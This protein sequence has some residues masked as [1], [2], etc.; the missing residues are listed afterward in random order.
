[1]TPIKQN[2]SLKDFDIYSKNIGLFINNKS[3][4]SSYFGLILTFFYCT[5]FIIILVYYIIKTVNK[6]QLKAYNSIRY[7]IETPSIKLNNDLFY[8]AFGAE[9][10]NNTSVFIDET[11]YYPKVIYYN[12]VKENDIWRNIEKL[13]LETEKCNLSKFNNG[14]KLLFKNNTLSTNYCVKDFGNIKLSGSYS[15]NEMA[16][17]KIILYPCKN[18]TKNS[19][20]CKPQN[21]IDQYLSASYISVQMQD[22]GITPTDYKNPTIPIIQDLYTSIGKSFYKEMLIFY[23]IVEIEND[24]GLFSKNTE[25]KTYIKFDR[26]FDTMHLRDESEYYE[27]KSLCRALIRLSDTIEVYNRIYGKMAEVFATTG[28]YLQF[29]NSLFCMLSFIFNNYNMK[30]T[31]IDNLFNYNLIKNKLVLKHDIE[32]SNKNEEYKSNIL[33]PNSYFKQKNQNSS[34]SYKKINSVQIIKKD[35]TKNN[36]NCIDNLKPITE[37]KFNL[38]SNQKSEKFNINDI[39]FNKMICTDKIIGNS[40][41]YGLNK[42]NN[43]NILNLNKNVNNF[44]QIKNVVTKKKN[45]RD[46]N[47]NIISFKFNIFEYYF[48]RNCFRTNNKSKFCLYEYGLEVIKNQLDIINVFNAN[49]FFNVLFKRLTKVRNDDKND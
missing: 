39:N 27:G 41:L 7:P 25:K 18:S 9:D 12:S 17:I 3:S 32:K 30:S 22:I 5:I 20:H 46:I 19:N 45:I 23:K 16:Y 35:K 2:L 10:P 6:G 37:I 42:I 21:I 4:L 36:V 47:N 11:I 24:I 28:G 29:I 43:D 40:S 33:I 44:E 38:Y 1:M 31:L 15:Y 26:E 13:Y 49:F 34:K 8:I 48:Y 14:H